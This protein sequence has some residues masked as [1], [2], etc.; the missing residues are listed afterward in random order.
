MLRF[1]S[2]LSVNKQLFA[3]NAVICTLVICAAV[4][5]WLSVQSIKQT[6]ATV[7]LFT[8]GEVALQVVLRG[9]NES[10][11]TRVQR[12]PRARVRAKACRISSRCSMR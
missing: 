1:F 12:C 4:A 5:A 7:S 9:V 3:A 6:D 8:N 2:K 10:I 11:L